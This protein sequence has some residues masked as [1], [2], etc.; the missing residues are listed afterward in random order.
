MKLLIIFLL[1][2]AFVFICE[3]TY[4]QTSGDTIQANKFRKLADKYGNEVS[5]DSST[6]YYRKAAN[7]YKSIAENQIDTLM[8]GEYLACLDSISFNYSNQF[9][10]EDS[11]NTLDSALNIAINFFGLEHPHTAAVYHNYGVLYHFEA[12][13][14]KSL[15]YLFMEAGIHKKNL[16]KDSMSLAD[17]HLWI[18]KD[19]IDKGVLDTAMVFINKCIEIL[20]VKPD[21]NRSKLA[22]AYENLAY[23]YHLKFEIEKALE[24]YLITLAFYK[25]SLGEKHYNVGT[26]Y[27]N[28]GNIYS[29]LSEKDKALELSLIH[30]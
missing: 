1:G 9:K 11:K 17:N 18:G 10:F 29:L 27:N 6:I 15:E 8:F 13:Y 24:Y 23:I 16:T 25:E 30:I 20:K 2:S 4:A 21:K 14:D 19:Y 5:L 26:A 7:I 12:K 22:E 3:N 28:L